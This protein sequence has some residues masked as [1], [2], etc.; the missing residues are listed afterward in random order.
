MHCKWFVAA[1]TAICAV[2]LLSAGEKPKRLLLVTHSGGFM[3]DS[4]LVAEQVLKEIGPKH[5]FEV[6]CYRYTG[7]PD[8]KVKYKV[9]VDGK[10]EE[11]EAPALARYSQ[12]F[13]E[14]TGEKGKTGD[15]V[16][17]SHCGRINKDTLAK[18]DAV[19]FFTTGS[20]A[21]APLTPD[22]VKDLVAWVK[23]G[24]AFAGTHCGADTLYNVPAY[25]ELIGAYFQTH[26]PGFQKIKLRVEDPKH[27]AA[28]SFTDGQMYE[29]EMYIFREAP[30]SRD[31]L[32]ILLSID[33][34][35]FQP[36]GGQ[37]ADKDY[38]VSWCHQVG[39]GRV[40]YTSL[41]HRREVWRDPKFQDH[42]LGGLNWAVGRL[43]G[44]ATP[45][46]KRAAP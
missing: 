36:R 24:G 7:D 22:E 21:T 25:G 1:I 3:H 5:G 10:D 43:P 39:K 17:P 15:E 32:R 11:R 9:K 2:G 8:Q 13:R 6:T 42:L 16:S 19:L 40:F 18:F 30:Y 26:P 38:A 4:I 29:D 33:P 14:R 12:Q 20:G 37:R 27:P 41:G 46:G 28:K 45:S 23:D 34:E 31:R 35:S 44:D